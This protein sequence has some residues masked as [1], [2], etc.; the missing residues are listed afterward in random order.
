L[1]AFV[2][3][4][5]VDLPFTGSTNI[6]SYPYVPAPLDPRTTED[7]LFL[8]VLAPKEGLNDGGPRLP[9]IVWIYGGGYVAGDK[10]TEDGTALIQRNIATGGEGLVYVAMNYRVRPSRHLSTS[11]EILIFPSWVHL[12]GSPARK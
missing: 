3:D 4:Y 2:D 5:L 1:T 7:C 6:S 12:A 8:D 10:S 11:L 9:V